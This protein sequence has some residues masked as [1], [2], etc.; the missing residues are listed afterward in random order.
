MCASVDPALVHM[1]GT[2]TP[3]RNLESSG[4]GTDAEIH[5][6]DDLLP[7]LDT[8]LPIW[9]S[10]LLGLSTSKAQRQNACMRYLRL[11]VQD[12]N[13][14][15]HDLVLYCAD[16]SRCSIAVPFTGVWPASRADRYPVSYGLFQ[17]DEWVRSIRKTYGAG[18][19][20]GDKNFTNVTAALL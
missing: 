17:S 12:S 4:R 14:A 13:C 20:G 8:R 1:V 7:N 16:Q 2:V 18:W 6:E 5:R 11:F 9:C 15:N 19:R 10:G 3:C